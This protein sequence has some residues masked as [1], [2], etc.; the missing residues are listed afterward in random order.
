M[1]VEQGQIVFLRV[2]QVTDILTQDSSLRG[3]PWATWRNSFGVL[4]GWFNR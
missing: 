1:K 2:V 4:T 3:Q